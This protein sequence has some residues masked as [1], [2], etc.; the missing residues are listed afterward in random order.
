M[1]DLLL[2]GGPDAK[3]KKADVVEAARHVLKREISNAEYSKVS[4][5]G[6]LCQIGKL[7]FVYFMHLYFLFFRFCIFVY[8]FFFWES[9][10]GSKG[11]FFF[12]SEKDLKGLMS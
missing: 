12:F 10:D 4:D 11:I 9:I 2:A 7:G 8:I 1:T 3:L 6:Q 5:V